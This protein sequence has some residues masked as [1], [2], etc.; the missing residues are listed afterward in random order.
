MSSLTTLPANEHLSA[1]YY[2]DS[3]SNTIPRLCIIR[4]TQGRNVSKSPC[5]FSPPNITSLLFS[6]VRLM[7][8]LGPGR[9][10]TLRVSSV[11]V[12]ELMSNRYKSFT[13]AVG[14]ARQCQFV[15]DTWQRRPEPGATIT[16]EEIM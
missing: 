5:V 8:R 12:N 7:E 10:R 15:S 4:E 1:A 13:G 2:H 11:Q 6:A 14:T 3:K 9:L 16:V